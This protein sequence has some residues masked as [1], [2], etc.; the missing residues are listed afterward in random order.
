MRPLGALAAA[1]VAVL[2]GGCAESASTLEDEVFAASATRLVPGRWNKR[3]GDASDQAATSVVRDSQNNVIFTGEMTGTVNFGGSN[4]TSLGQTD[5]F[6]VK[7]DAAGA[8]VWSKR[9]GATQ[10]DSGVAVAVDSLDN[11]YLAAKTKGTVTFGCNTHASVGDDDI[12]IAKLN[13]NGLCAWSYVFGS[14]GPQTVTSIDVDAS[15]AA[16]IAGHFTGTVKFGVGGRLTSAGGTDIFVAKF[17]ANSV[18]MFARRFGDASDQVATSV[19]ADAASNILV[20][21]SFAGTL[22]I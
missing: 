17:H 21:G 4:L 15:D 9:Y 12:L 10:A 22:N 11:I 7:L 16:I 8:H 2:I 3:F 13:P 1:L 5:I 6:L 14:A 18:P 20:G 19:H